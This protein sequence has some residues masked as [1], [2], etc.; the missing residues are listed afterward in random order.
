MADRR[1]PLGSVRQKRSTRPAPRPM[2]PRFQNNSCTLRDEAAMCP[3]ERNLVSR[4]HVCCGWTSNRHGSRRPARQ[5]RRVMISSSE[6]RHH[7]RL[8]RPLFLVELCCCL[9]PSLFAIRRLEPTSTA[10]ASASCRARPRRNR[11]A[12]PYVND[13]DRGNSIEDE[14]AVS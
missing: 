11:S 5:Q 1:L 13:M 3:L 12:G 8:R 14:P 10:P 2:K 9:Q 4:A 6:N 7:Y